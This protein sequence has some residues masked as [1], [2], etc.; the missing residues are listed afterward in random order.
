MNSIRTYPAQAD[1]QCETYKWL[2]TVFT[3]ADLWLIGVDEDSW[4]TEWAT[5]TITLNHALVCPSDW[6]FV[7]QV[8]SSFWSWLDVHVSNT[9]ENS[10]M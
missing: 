4:V 2:A 10:A 8:D 9:S 6:L 3:W 5:A 7:D 1:H